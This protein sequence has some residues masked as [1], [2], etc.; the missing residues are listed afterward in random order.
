MI[1]INH[2]TPSRGPPMPIAG[3]LIRRRG[4]W[5]KIDE[6]LKSGSH[7]AFKKNICKN[8][9]TVDSFPTL[10]SYIVYNGSSTE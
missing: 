4:G 1:G 9:V 8:L 10:A 2:S 5:L 3:D 6:S 7:P